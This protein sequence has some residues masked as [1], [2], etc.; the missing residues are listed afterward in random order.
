MYATVSFRLAIP[1][2]TAGV[3]RAAPSFAPTR[4]YV[5]DAVR[6]ARLKT[7]ISQFSSVETL[8][9]AIEAIRVSMFV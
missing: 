4:N 5:F 9:C 2:A 1:F 8:G 3:L 7:S 6:I